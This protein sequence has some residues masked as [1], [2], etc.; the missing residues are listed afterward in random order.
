MAR[1][2]EEEY[3]Y[4]SEPETESEDDAEDDAQSASGSD[5]EGN[6]TTSPLKVRG[7]LGRPQ[8][9]CASFQ[10]LLRVEGDKVKATAGSE[11]PK[12][13][14]P[15]FPVSTYA[16]PRDACEFLS[17]SLFLWSPPDQYKPFKIKCPNTTVG[18]HN[19]NK[20]QHRD[21]LVFDLDGPVFLRRGHFRCQKPECPRR[22]KGYVAR[23]EGFP[24]YPFVHTAKR[25]FTERLHILIVNSISQGVT[26]AQMVKNIEET[27]RREYFRRKVEVQHNVCRNP[28]NEQ[29][30]QA[31]FHP[32]GPVVYPE[33]KRSKLKDCTNS[34]I[35]LHWWEM[36]PSS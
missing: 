19:L 28:T 32:G 1:I 23:D 11:R 36:K 25:A 29:A 27:Q 13:V 5:S 6:G 7:P 26:A 14:H 2:G 24:F 20:D 16:R 33:L 34:L 18:P 31:L 3:E 30:Q 21:I 8:Y 15:S 17:P 4:D 10:N 35:F 12:F 22:N 9:M